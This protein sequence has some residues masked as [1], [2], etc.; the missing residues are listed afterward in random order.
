MPETSGLLLGLS[1]ALAWGVTDIVGTLAGRRIGSL[2][3]TAIADLASLAILATLCAATGARLPD[4]PVLVL[5]ALAVGCLAGLAY[6]AFYTALQLGPLSVVSPVVSLYGGLTV[7]LSVLLLGERLSAGQGIGALVATAGVA[8]VG[9]K[10]ERDW[11]QTRLVG[12]GVAFGLVSLVAFAVVTVGLA[13][14]MRA[15]GWLPIL[16]LSR[17]GNTALVLAI[18][19]YRS[20]RAAPPAGTPEAAPVTRLA[21]GQAAATGMLDVVGS[22][23]WGFGLVIASTWLVGLASSFGPVV[24]VL[25]GV[26]MFGERLRPL[27]WAG[28]GLVAL[29]VIL[30]GLG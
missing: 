27:Q 26:A 5:T 19:G 23:A 28:L 15:A 2:R 29:S 4:D 12:P 20:L 13:G 21:L 30:L 17:A 3:T 16:L 10:F 7:V 25:G 8:L 6:L 18:V 22:A 24:A 11:R 1:A 14:P 9:V